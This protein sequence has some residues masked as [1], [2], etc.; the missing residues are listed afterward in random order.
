MAAPDTPS[1]W[2]ILRDVTNTIIAAMSMLVAFLVYRYQRTQDERATA[3]SARQQERTTR[4]EWVRLLIIEPNRD[5][6]LEFFL[7]L[8]RTLGG[9]N[10]APLRLDERIQVASELDMHFREFDRRFLSYFD[11]IN[12]LATHSSHRQLIEDLQ[13]TLSND[14]DQFQDSDYLNSYRRM[15]QHVISCRNEFL[16][17]IYSLSTR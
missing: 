12:L 2:D 14:L 3:E 4:L 9:A 17:A 15:I 10:H 13:E 5:Y 16:S 1:F 8:E 6:I 7:H 11:S